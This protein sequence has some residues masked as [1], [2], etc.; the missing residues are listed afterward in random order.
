MRNSSSAVRLRSLTDS[1]WRRPLLVAVALSVAACFLL[2]EDAKPPE[3][4][5][6][7]K[8][9]KQLDSVK[10]AA[11]S[12]GTRTPKATD[13]S[14]VGTKGVAE[15]TDCSA[16]IE[17]GSLTVSA[18]GASLRFEYTTVSWGEAP[19]SLEKKTTA[20]SGKVGVTDRGS[21]LSE[22]VT[23]RESGFEND[24]V[25]S[26]SG[27]NG[28]LELSG[29][30]TT[31]LK[32]ER[33]F[34]GD[35]DSPDFETDGAITF[36]DAAG[37]RC[38][39]ICPTVV[40]D[41]VG[42]SETLMVRYS[43]TKSGYAFK[44]RTPSAWLKD[45]SFPITID[46]LIGSPAAA[47]PVN[48][49]YD[50]TDSQSA[51][52]SSVYFV[53]FARRE[54]W[55]AN[56][57]CARLINA[58]GSLNGN[59]WFV[60][61]GSSDQRKPDVAYSPASGGVFGVAYLEGN[62]GNVILKRY[63]AAGT[64]LGSHTV[65]NSAT[66][67]AGKSVSI[68]TD[69]SGDFLIVFTGS[70]FSNP[71]KVWGERRSASGT[72]LTEDTQISVGSSSGDFMSNPDVVW[73][74]TLSEWFLIWQKTQTDLRG[75]GWNNTLS[76]STTNEVT[77]ATNLYSGD[78][79]HVA[80]N[81]TDNEYMVAFADS[82][83]S[84]KGQRIE[85][86]D[87]A[88]VG[89]QFTI[90]T[91]AAY[92]PMRRPS[93]AYSVGAHRFLACFTKYTTTSAGGIA[94]QVVSAT[95]TP[96][97]SWFS[98]NDDTTTIEDRSALS[99]NAGA[100]EQLATWTDE[101]SWAN[102]DII[103]YVRMEITPPVTPSVTA[104]DAY[105]GETKIILTWA[106]GSETDLYG[107]NVRR[108]TAAGG[109]YGSP[110]YVAPPGG[111]T[112]TYEDTG[113]S[114]NV[115]YYYVVES[116][117]T[118]QNFSDYSAEV[119]EIID[120]AAPAVPTGLA[121]T[122]GDSQVSL[123]W[124]ANSEPDLAG[125]NAYYRMTGSPDWIKKNTSLIPTADYVVTGLSNGVSYDFAVSAVD[126]EPN[127]SAKSATISKTP[128]DAVPPAAP[129][130]LAGTPADMQVDLTWTANGEG[131]LAGYNVYCRTTSPP[132]SW[133][134]K[135]GALLG[136]PGFSVTGL[137][138]G[139]SYDFAVTAKDTSGNESEMCTPISVTPA[140][141]IPPAVP[142]GLAGTAGDTLVD[143]TWTA[144]SESDLAGYK[145][146]YR[147]TGD[148]TWIEI[149]PLVGS[150]SYSVTGLTNWLSYD[151]AVSAKDTSGNESAKSSSITDWPE[152]AISP[153]T[154]NSSNNR[155]TNDSTPTITGTST[156][157]WT[158]TLYE[159]TESLGSDTVAS[160]GTFSFPTLTLDDD[161][162]VI[163]AKVTPPLPGAPTSGYSSGVTVIVDT[164]PPATPTG[165]QIIA[166]NNWIDLRWDANTED[167][168]L[169]YDVFRKV[170]G[171]TDPWEKL[172]TNPLVEN[173]YVDYDVLN[174]TSYSYKVT[175]VD[176]ALDED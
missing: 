91:G 127:E 172:N 120:T 121:G 89:S 164:T 71:P 118:H 129:V 128:A 115:T 47:T 159:G 19:K 161:E 156:R 4:G 112:V 31:N 30:I 25:I 148:T 87:A 95:G 154:L 66:C 126:T 150:P 117:D 90:A 132:G 6:G 3:D 130:G 2:A 153:P 93:I 149:G 110:I 81:S 94:G 44:V 136:S 166:G 57:V 88:S 100:D 151:F 29:S 80:W 85:P 124:T 106:K 74:S 111:S 137:D 165:L 17:D 125:Y 54:S 173:R 168:L 14:Q 77:I 9:G 158:V 171:S 82:S 102:E 22:K 40:K 56:D 51:F 157:G 11:E 16:T 79:P 49:G 140:D 18:G 145:V 23:V 33:T 107:Y 141:A 113:I 45:A 58:D 52:G 143:L 15:S 163:Q 146:Y 20:F 152:G 116:L 73:N 60:A 135:N 133:E 39:C 61:S 86:A 175:A 24:L 62:N 59:P 42:K 131:D 83:D 169:G 76:A 21:G 114:T 10:S 105:P 69:S 65:N 155:K 108:A 26:A 96:I 28:D 63:N 36:L 109:P 1:F 147:V 70:L 41:A 64:Y 122:I 170:T 53:T 98:V 55:N 35:P 50:F 103:S 99:V 92:A 37:I 174:G 38:L 162:H 48:N 46:P 144:N 27:G 75:M 142:T 123:T 84:V 8:S 119:S 138:N 34:P 67:N 97:G 139:V 5:V 134:Q 43:T 7:E 32:I 68:C 104:S 176:D 78:V 12:P 13:F 167:D 72:V 160:D 101:A